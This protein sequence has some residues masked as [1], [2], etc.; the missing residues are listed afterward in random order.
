MKRS[1]LMFLVIGLAIIFS[2]C[3][4]D[5]SLAPDLNHSD[6]EISLKASKIPFTGTSTPASLPIGGDTTLLPNGKTLI[7]GVTADWYDHSDS[8]AGMITG[9]SHWLINSLT[10]PDGSAKLWGKAEIIVDGENGI[11]KWELSWHGYLTP[12]DDGSGFEIICDANGQGKEGI[13]Q[14]MV[15][16]WTYT[17]NFD[18]SNP[19]TTF[20]YAT[21][22]YIK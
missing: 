5:N 18:F 3:S 6:Q 21:E 22:G 14:G 1:N 17:M 16:K 19:G 2:G 9:T 11:G 7:K 13:V 15:G 8:C 10:E 20:F 12:N 4:K